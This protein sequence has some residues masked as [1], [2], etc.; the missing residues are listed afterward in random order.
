MKNWPIH[1]LVILNHKQN[2]VLIF[3]EWNN[4]KKNIS[5]YCTVHLKGRGS[6]NT[7]RSLALLTHYFV[8]ESNITYYLMT[9]Q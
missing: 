7:S 8:I 4:L 3:I 5:R 1:Y 2:G 6:Q 9:I